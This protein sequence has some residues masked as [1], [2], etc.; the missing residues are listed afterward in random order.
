MPGSREDEKK[1]FF[2]SFTTNPAGWETRMNL[3]LAD[4]IIKAHGGK[5][6]VSSEK[7]SGTEMKILVPNSIT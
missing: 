1:R 5:M 2:C 6:N 7:G 4:K 3:S